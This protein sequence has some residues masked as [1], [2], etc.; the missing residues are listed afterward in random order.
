M[1]TKQQ[2]TTKTQAKRSPAKPRKP[3]KT[4]GDLSG[5]PLIE[6]GNAPIHLNRHGQEIVVRCLTTIAVFPVQ[7]FRDWWAKVLT[8]NPTLPIR[9]QENQVSVSARMKGEGNDQKCVFT[10]LIVAQADDLQ[11]VD[12]PLR[13]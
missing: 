5:E 10:L 8:G 12:D 13:N 11:R 6:W 7:E 2:T 3:A 4:V 1:A 9:D